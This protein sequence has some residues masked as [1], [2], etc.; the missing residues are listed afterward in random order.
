MTARIDARSLQDRLRHAKQLTMAI[1]LMLVVGASVYLTV[2]FQDARER[3]LSE[4]E[5]LARLLESE[6]AGQL[7]AV[8]G[9]MAVVGEMMRR[10]VQGGDPA[11]LSRALVGAL[12][13]SR[14]VRSLSYLDESGRVLASSAASDVGAQV[15]LK[16]LGI[17]FTKKFALGRFLSGRDL[18]NP[19]APAGAR[20]P[21]M[22][23]MGEQLQGA[24]GYVIAVLN[25]DGLAMHY[26]LLGGEPGKR[27]ALLSYGGTVLVTGE[28]SIAV[29]GT[30]VSH[31][32]PF[33]TYLPGKQ[34]GEYVG[35]AIDPG[36]QLAAFRTVRSWPLVMLVQNPHSVVWTT[37]L[38]SFF[39]V[40][41]ITF[42]LLIGLIIIASVVIRDAKRQAAAHADVELSEARQQAN[43][44]IGLDAI[45]TI[46]VKGMIRHFNAAA[47]SMF[48]YA[49]Q[50]AEGSPMAEMLIPPALRSSH[51]IGIARLRAGGEERILRKR[52]EVEAMRR[53]G[54]VFPIEIAIVPVETT[55]GLWFTSTIRDITRRKADEKAIGESETRFRATFEQSAVGMIHQAQ[56]GR[57]LRVNSTM[58]EML[59]YTE[60]EFIALDA[61][62]LIH[63][64][65]VET[66]EQGVQALFGGTLAVWRQDKRYRHKRGHYVWTRLT[67]AMV[68]AEPESDYMSCV[69]EDVTEQTRT[70]AE[71]DAAQK[72]E[73]E[74][75]LRIQQSLLVGGTPT[76]IAGLDFAA[77]SQPSRGI[78]GDFYDVMDLGQGVID[79]LAG[80]VMGKGVPAAL[81]GAATKMQFAR[82]MTRLMVH[83]VPSPAEVLE[84]MDRAVGP[85][86]QALNAFV[87]LVYLRIDCNNNTVTWVGCGHEEPM[88][89]RQNG[90]FEVLANQLPPFGVLTLPRYEQ[91]TK[92]FGPDDHL[93]MWSDGVSDAIFSD[94]SRIGAARV[95]ALVVRALA[96]H[97][98]PA[99]SLQSVRRAIQRTEATITDDLT[100]LLVGRRTQAADGR[101]LELEVALTSIKPAR[102]FVQQE[103]DTV[104]LSPERAGPLTVAVIE[105]V[106][107]VIRHGRGLTAGAPL[108]LSSKRSV[109]ALV[110]QIRYF[111]D[112][113][114]PPAVI[115]DSDFAQHPESGFGLLIMQRASDRLEHNYRD[116]ANILRLAVT[117]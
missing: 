9:V 51:A 53:D 3:R 11:E 64:N 31:L 26:G 61:R 32:P 104:G 80:D 48:G 86:L 52:I 91:E 111:G 100:M 18:A 8:R 78:D 37:W 34:S 113:F 13:A 49:R 66:G 90:S 88:L 21:G 84:H 114:E 74:I 94:G 68:R 75:G 17:D 4:L 102:I 62:R 27:S 5:T 92:A 54:S 42:A 41:G 117:L 85:H 105:A 65:D 45:V 57:L 59:G 28:E 103:C 101:R 81:L 12:A 14:T 38:G 98:T 43:L 76:D 2:V 106:T 16:R 22:L 116:G 93:F 115:L 110:I 83:G 7:D 55:E 107:N 23:L 35:A 95:R 50:E 25:P 33:K 6:T 36:K 96:E 109:D 40:L 20:S 77:F 63:P 1:A 112:Y 73:L 108:E 82:S 72:R 24:K 46:D 29:P 15:D 79:I 71:L 30:D 87:T 60:A 19:D 69:I 39:P 44:E 97:Q 67:A 89:V 58:C 70:R 99:M 56:D 10:N 47:E